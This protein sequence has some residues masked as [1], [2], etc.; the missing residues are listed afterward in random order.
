MLRFQACAHGLPRRAATI[1]R[2]TTTPVRCAPRNLSLVV[3]WRYQRVERFVFT[4]QT[5]RHPHAS[6]RRSPYRWERAR[7]LHTCS[8][9]LRLLRHR[10]AKLRIYG[11]TGGGDGDGF[12]VSNLRRWASKP[13]SWWHATCRQDM[14]NVLHHSDCILMCTG[15]C[16]RNFLTRRES[17]TSACLQL[18]QQIHKLASEAMT[19]IFPAVK[20]ENTRRSASARSRTLELTSGLPGGTL[21]LARERAAGTLSLPELACC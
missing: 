11:E 12:G 19:L 17:S 13:V 9:K 4:S 1:G 8:L 20:P 15:V 21:H 7:R 16:C 14:H 18:M 5:P 6:G 2:L 10:R 3:I